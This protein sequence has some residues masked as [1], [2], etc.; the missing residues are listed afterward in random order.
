MTYVY[1]KHGGQDITAKRIGKENAASFV[2]GILYASS[3]VD[4][5]LAIDAY[6][7]ASVD[8]RGQTLVFDDFKLKHVE[9]ETY[10]ATV[11]YLHPDNQKNEEEQSNDAPQL[12]FDATGRQTH[13][14]H[15]YKTLRA[16]PAGLKDKHSQAIGVERTAKG[17]L[18]IHGTDTVIPALKLTVSAKI[19]QPP[20]PFEY[21]RKLARLVGRVN[22]NPWNGFAKWEL[23]FLG[24]KITGKRREKWTIDLDFDCDQEITEADNFMIGQW[25]PIHKEGHAHLWVEWKQVNK[26]VNSG[27]PVTMVAEPD[28][29][30]IEQ[31]CFEF[32]LADLG[33]T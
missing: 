3:D 26:S 32:D 21:G 4:A 11:S 29:V 27:D 1:P 16:Y 5:L 31:V 25:G 22:R 9:C 19:P 8:V 28:A 6:K 18:K 23:Q 17:Q 12:T 15:S 20:N 33:L 14:T 2:Y 30:F 24:G 7:P 13:I 10:E